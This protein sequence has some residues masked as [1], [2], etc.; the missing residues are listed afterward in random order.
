MFTLT[1]FLILHSNIH[2]KMLGLFE[3]PDQHNTTTL[4]S[5]LSRVS[6]E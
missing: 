6:V 5:Q 1:L 2:V 3:H 4:A